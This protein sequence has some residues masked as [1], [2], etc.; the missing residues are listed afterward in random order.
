MATV[1]ERP[2]GVRWHCPSPAQQVTRTIVHRRCLH[3]GGPTST[4]HGGSDGRCRWAD[5]TREPGDALLSE[6]QMQDTAA[7]VSEVC[8]ETTVVVDTLGP[9]RHRLL[10]RYLC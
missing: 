1:E 8:V 5:P 2:I 7:N 3:E 4:R 9:T 6:L 10:D